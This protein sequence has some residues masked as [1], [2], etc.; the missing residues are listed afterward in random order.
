M[1]EK[2]TTRTI[3]CV[4]D[5]QGVLD[6]YR[7]VLSPPET[8][9]VADILA[10]AGETEGPGT[11]ARTRFDLIIADAGEKAVSEVRKLLDNNGR[12]AAAFVDMR[13]PGGIDG[14]E[15]IRQLR[16]LDDSIHCAVVTAYTDRSVT[17]IRELFP[18]NH[19]DELL[20]FKKPFSPE[21]LEQSALNLVS[22]WNRKRQLGEQLRAIEKNK[23]GLAQILHAVSTL[24][25]VPPH[26]VHYLLPGVLVQLLAM[27]EADDGFVLLR[28]NEDGGFH[29]GV[30]RFDKQKPAMEMVCGAADMED[31]INKNRLLTRDD[32]CFMPLK[33]KDGVRGCIFIERKGIAETLDLPLMNL[34]RNQIVHLLLTSIY[35]NEVNAR[36]E[37]AIT[38]PLTGL[39]NRRFLLKRLRE[40]I[41]RSNRSQQWLSVLMIDLDDFKRINDTYGHDAG[42]GVLEEVGKIMRLA[43]RD[44]D[45]VGQSLKQIGELDQ[46]AIRYGG[47]E[48][49]IILLNTD[50]D[51][52]LIV[53][54]R[55]RKKIAAQKYIFS[56]RAVKITASTGI[57]S[58]LF[59]GGEREETEVDAEMTTII[60]KADEALYQAKNSGKNK[61][62]VLP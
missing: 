8:D 20:Y 33:L 53:A 49:C 62:V 6:S 19:Q 50:Q 47:E 36:E 22:S 21:E 17:Q 40:E 27:V 13:M 42:D 10:L 35:H 24:S 30:G 56:G 52:A 18:E 34:F 26:S 59:K 55:I 32:C 28:D 41:S 7:Q 61:V 45:L 37:E 11:V 43:V 31:A 54:E 39:F 58:Q 1:A 2:W 60:N 14:F 15:T 44:Y 38:D 3:V 12:V 4:D 9:A 16:E 23:Q 48:F 5:E 25:R 46:F 57:H 51:A 29:S